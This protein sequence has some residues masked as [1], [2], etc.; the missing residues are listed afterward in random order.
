MAPE[1]RRWPTRLAI[2]AGLLLTA[3]AVLL[4]L[5]APVD[6]AAYEPPPAPEMAGPYAVNRSLAAAERLAEGE[7]HGPED[8]AVAPDGTAYLGT[9]DGKIVR[10]SAGGSEVATVVDT[11]GRPLG[12]AFDAEGRLLVADG[13]RGL[14]RV[15][16]DGRGDEPEV[17][18]T[19]AAGVPFGFT[20]DLDVASDGRIY[21]SDA[22]SRFGVGEYLY[23]LLEARPH[24]RLLRH[25]PATGVTELLAQGLYFANGIALSR[26]EDFV[27]VNE[28]YRYRITRYWLKGPKAGTSEIFIDNLPGFPDGVSSNRRGTFWVALFTVRNATMDRLHPYPFAKAFLSKLP[29]FLW[30]KPAPYGLV[31]ALDEQGRVLRTLQDPG[32]AVIPQVTSAEEAG[33]Y[34]YL[35]N[36]DRDYFARV[37]L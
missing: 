3:L 17:L 19:G 31:I 9:E 37:R 5:P 12:L 10:V 14:L 36:L 2:T 1:P 6:P 20:D 11:G 25:D 26:D 8:V 34:L 29:R 23:D 7:I 27:L 21:F 24:G 30:P 13:I 33:G 4:L 16:V 32:G 22:S 15:A 28:T 35:G 18:S